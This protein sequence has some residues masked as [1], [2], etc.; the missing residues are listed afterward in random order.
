M[1]SAVDADITPSLQVFSSWKVDGALCLSPCDWVMAAKVVEAECDNILSAK[2]T[3][4]ASF[5]EAD[6]NRDGLLGKS[7]LV[8]LGV[9]R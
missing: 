3:G 4:E 8:K 9:E 6:R 2:W 1:F 5:A 7:D